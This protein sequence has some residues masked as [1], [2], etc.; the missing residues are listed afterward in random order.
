MQSQSANKVQ[1]VTTELNSDRL[2]NLQLSQTDTIYRPVPHPE[3]STLPPATPVWRVRFDL[4]FN[5]RIYLALELNGEAVLGRGDEAGKIVS[6]DHFDADNLGVSRRHLVLRPTE[7]KLYLVDLG[8]TN[9]TRINGRSIGVNTPYS[10]A[11]GDI[12]ALGQLEFVVRIIRTPASHATAHREEMDLADLISPLA[13]AITSQLTMDEVLKQALKMT[14]ELTGVAEA[15]IWLVNEQTGE[16]F[17]EA[18]QGIENKQIRHMRL[19]VA[20]SLAG[21]VIEAGQPVRAN[22]QVGGEQIKVKTGYLVEAVIYVPITLAGVT[23]GVLM[24]AHQTNGKQITARD[25]RVILTIADFTAVAVQ[26]AR[27][28][29]ATSSTLTRRVKVMTALNYA[30]SY[31]LKQWVNAI[32][33]YSGLLQTYGPFDEDITGI[34]GQITNAGDNIAG[35]LE[36]LI[37]VAALCEEPIFEQAP[38]DLLEIVGRAVNDMYRAAAAKSTTLDFQLNGEPYYILGDAAHLYRSV[39]NLIDNAIKYSPPEAQVFVTLSFS[40]NEVIILVRDTGPGIPEDDL[41]LLF[42]KY[43]RGNQTSP[44]QAGI[45]L[46]LELVR[47][48]AEMHRGIVIARNAEHD[49]AEFIITLPATLRTS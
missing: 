7:A 22:R 2:W 41:P 25:E 43:F 36:Q 45:G 12:L 10:V 46:G 27:L 3:G 34:I 31:N 44:E 4:T 28:Y 29:Q 17:L 16:L 26:N 33:G 48:T 11:N 19:S 13:R 49:G 40:S 8:S 5:P 39:Y 1:Q 14:L 9:G 30:L 20:D 15:S 37:E 42:D 38:C 6:L 47:V 24:A 32:I 35:L 18:E 23:F 21:T